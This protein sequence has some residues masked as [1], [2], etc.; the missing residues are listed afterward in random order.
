MSAVDTAPLT[1]NAP[2]AGGL[3]SE[4]G[5][6]RMAKVEAL[7]LASD[8]LREPLASELE[9]EESHF[10]NGAVQILKFHGSYQQ[11]NRDQRHRDWSMMLRLRSPGGWASPSYWSGT[12]AWCGCVGVA[13][14]GRA[15]SAWWCA[16]PRAVPTWNSA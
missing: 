10:S 6:S 7:K 5:A 3:L 15:G 13:L 11:T 2:T 16:L 1:Q 4:N 9:N 8:H 14:S 12:P